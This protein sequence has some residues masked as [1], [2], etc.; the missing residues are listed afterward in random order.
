MH[1]RTYHRYM[2]EIDAAEAEGILAFLAAR[3]GK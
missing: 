3:P 1:W 2:D